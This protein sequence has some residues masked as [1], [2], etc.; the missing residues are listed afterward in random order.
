MTEKPTNQKSE[1]AELMTHLGETERPLEVIRKAD[2]K[3]FRELEIER[4]YD[5]E[6]QRKESEFR[7]YNPEFF[8]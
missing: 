3:A 5:P 1:C 2:D 4:L 6:Y 8:K 7:R